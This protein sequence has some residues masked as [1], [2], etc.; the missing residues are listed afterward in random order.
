VNDRLCTVE[1]C[2]NGGKL[3]RGWCNKHY[4]RWWRSNHPAPATRKTTAAG[5]QRITRNAHW[6]ECVTPNESGCLVWQ[7]VIDRYGYGKR[8][9]RFAHRLAYEAEV[10]PI[11][12]GLVIDHLCRNRACVN[13]EHLEPVTLYENLLRGGPGSAAHNAAKVEC[14][15][16]HPFDEENTYINKR[17]HRSCRACNRLAVQRYQANKR[18]ITT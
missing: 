14:R 6:R 11:P 15:A 10:G 12:E 7:G 13:P 2:G 9:A 18:G 1:G 3:R 17:G 16:G 4:R 5:R 8:G